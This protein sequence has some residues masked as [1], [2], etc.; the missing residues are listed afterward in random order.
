M[1][2]LLGGGEPLEESIHQSAGAQQAFER[3]ESRLAPEG[4]VGLASGGRVGL[5]DGDVALAA[6][7][8]AHEQG[9]DPP[10]A[11]LLQHAQGLA[12]ER[13]DC[14]GDGYRFERCFEM[15]SV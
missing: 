12:A 9:R 3:A 4:G 1:V 10:P 8:E 11:K 13:M 15:G 6:V 5:G 2:G 7:R 14:A